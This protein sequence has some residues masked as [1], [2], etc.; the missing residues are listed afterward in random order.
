MGKSI[1]KWKDWLRTWSDWGKQLLKV[2]VCS[3]KLHNARAQAGL[4]FTRIS[5]QSISCYILSRNATEF[6]SSLLKAG[7]I[8]FFQRFHKT[9][10]VPGTNRI[11]GRRYRQKGKEYKRLWKNT[12]PESKSTFLKHENLKAK[13]LQ[14]SQGHL[15]LKDCIRN[16]YGY[17][18]MQ[19]STLVKH[20]HWSAL[21]LAI[22]Y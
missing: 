13:V 10:T 19:I 22:N 18:K 2:E 5:E 8:Y 4:L 15:L 14:T 6:I 9:N 20:C 21:L 17:R 1:S 16:I 12:K 11:D 7:I 3:A